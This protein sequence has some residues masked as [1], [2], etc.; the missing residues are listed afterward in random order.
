[1]TPGSILLGVALLGVVV[2][3]LARP[4]IVP[5]RPRGSVTARQALLAQKERLLERIRE[6][7]FDYET[8][9]IPPDVYEPQRASLLAEAAAVLQQLD[10]LTDGTSAE[11]QPVSAD[12]DAEIEAAI[13]RLRQQAAGQPAAAA[14]AARSNGHKKGGFCPQCGQPTD[15]NDK[16]C[17]ACGHKLRAPARA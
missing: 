2:L 9:K 1:M 17:A 4:F 12:V 8:A 14:A 6:L 13:A 3:I 10:A 11:P 5:R 7:D 16:F 15:A